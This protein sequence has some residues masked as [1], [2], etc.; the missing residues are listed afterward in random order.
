[1][2]EVLK[3]TGAKR[4]SPPISQRM[5]SLPHVTWLILN[6]GNIRIGRVEPLDGIAVAGD[7]RK[8][9]ATLVRRENETVEA[10]LRRLDTAVGHAVNTGAA[11]NEIGDAELVLSAPSA[12]KSGKR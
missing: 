6:G 12:R 5:G 9:L 8:A 10:L 3:T 7:A 2:I 4:D 11:I 1:L